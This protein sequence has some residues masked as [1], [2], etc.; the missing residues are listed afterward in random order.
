M[1]IKIVAFGEGNTS[2]IKFALD[3]RFDIYSDEL[4]I[5]K[6]SEFDG[7]EKESTHYLLFI[8]DIPVGVCRWRK[9]KKHILI[10]RFGIKKEYR[11]N[12]YG[13]LL[14]KFVLKELILSKKDIKILST[15]KSVAF[16][17]LMHFGKEVDKIEVSGIKLLILLLKNKN[18]NNA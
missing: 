11:G 6:F 2:Y 4:N 5:D 10:D 1:D 15:E 8:N 17:N 16:L 14:L 12:G 18:N 9:E 13:L 7:L 3:I